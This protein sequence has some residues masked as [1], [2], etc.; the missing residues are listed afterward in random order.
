VWSNALGVGSFIGL[1]S[2]VSFLADAAGKVVRVYSDVDPGVH[3]TQVLDDARSA[4]LLA[5]GEGD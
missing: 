3:A 5:H 1:D 4:G 2:R